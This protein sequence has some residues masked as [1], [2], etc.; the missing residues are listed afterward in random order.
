MLLVLFV[1]CM[2][3]NVA[4]LRIG[5]LSRF[6]MCDQEISLPKGNYMEDKRKKSYL[7]LNTG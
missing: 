3:V 1:Q 6:G 4:Q 2:Q 5:S 7:V